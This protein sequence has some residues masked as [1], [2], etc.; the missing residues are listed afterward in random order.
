MPDAAT[1][2]PATVKTSGPGY[3]AYLWRYDAPVTALAQLPGFIGFGLGDG[4][5][6]LRGTAAPDMPAER[7]SLH[8]ESLLS[9]TAH[10]GL[11]GFV[12]GGLDGAVQFF[13]PGEDPRQLAQRK[14][15]WIEH[16]A[17]SPDGALVAFAAGRE[18]VL[19]DAKGAE[20]AGFTDHPSTLT[21]IAF[22]NRSK[23]LAVSHYGGVSLWWVKS[24]AQKPKRLVWT[25]SHVAI[26][27]SPDGR[28]IMTATQDCELHGWRTDD[29]ADMRMSGYPNKPRSMSW[30]HNSKI[31]ATSGAEAA[32]CWDCSGKGPMGSKPLEMNAGTVVTQVAFHPRHGILAT[33][34]ADG[35]LV[36]GRLGDQRSM[37]LEQVGPA[38]IAGLSWSADGRYLAAGA[39]DGAAAILDFQET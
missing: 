32:V 23:R 36:L 17:I 8:D 13:A 20:L 16:L 27:W 3:R 10:A 22:N 29:F 6:A 28:F 5:L 18:A 12:S 38:A 31:L 26:S 14:N 30:T 39:E 1:E 7:I 34:H 37:K 35:S 33:G 25:G 2:N 15:K 11:G 24:A 21:G 19:L 4:S 9:L